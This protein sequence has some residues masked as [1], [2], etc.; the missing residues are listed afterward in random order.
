MKIALKKMSE[1][2]GLEQSA[3]TR[4]RTRTKTRT[5]A[6]DLTVGIARY[7]ISR[8]VFSYQSCLIRKQEWHC[9]FFLSFEQ[10]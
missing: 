5:P 6:A 9:L 7:L 10:D 2:E 1:K 4:A 8:P 3:K